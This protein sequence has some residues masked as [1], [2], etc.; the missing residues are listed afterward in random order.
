MIA[1]PYQQHTVLEDSGM[2][3]KSR[4]MKSFENSNIYPSKLKL[5]CDTP[6]KTFQHIQRMKVFFLQSPTKKL[7]QEIRK[8]SKTN[9]ST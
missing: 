7:Q 4:Q 3:L 1:T 9:T 2:S 8:E 5:K 6:I